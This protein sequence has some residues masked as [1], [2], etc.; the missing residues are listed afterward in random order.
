MEKMGD[1]RFKP[2]FL[3]LRWVETSLSTQKV[4]LF[5]FRKNDILLQCYLLVGR[6]RLMKLERVILIGLSLAAVGCGPSDC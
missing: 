2:L 3:R 4:V 1:F 5:R 6:Y